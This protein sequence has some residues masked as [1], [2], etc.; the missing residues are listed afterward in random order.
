MKNVVKLKMICIASLLLGGCLTNVQY[1]YI[2]DTDNQV[3]SQRKITNKNTYAS[4]WVA[5]FP[6]EYCDG[7]VSITAEDF[8]K[9]R[10]K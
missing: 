6:L 2:I 5:D 8:A 4:K 1:I 7:N 9:F 10:G 3:C